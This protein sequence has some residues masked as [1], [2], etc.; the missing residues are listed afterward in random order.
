MVVV[1]SAAGVVVGGSV[2][3]TVTVFVHPINS[4]ENPS[5]TH[6]ENFLLVGIGM[7]FPI[8]WYLFRFLTQIDPASSRMTLTV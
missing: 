3:T 1:A 8:S 2:S 6:L 4:T 5:N 7:K